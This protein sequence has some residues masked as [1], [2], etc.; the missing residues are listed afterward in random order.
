MPLREKDRYATPPPPLTANHVSQ[1]PPLPNLVRWGHPVFVVCVHS[2]ANTAF[3]WPSTALSL[4]VFTACHGHGT[5][6]HCPSLTFRCF[7][8]TLDYDFKNGNLVRHRLCLVLPLHSRLRHCYCLVCYHCLHGEGTA[9]AL[10]LHCLRG[11]GTAFAVCASTAHAA[12]NGAFPCSFHCLSSPVP[13]P[14]RKTAPCFAAKDSAFCLVCFHCRHSY[15]CMMAVTA[16]GCSGHVRA[17]KQPLR[18][19]RAAGRAQG[20]WGHCHG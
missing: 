6:F 9:F 18:A 4:R 15:C 2:G 20:D 8:Q 5:A 16:L 10:C 3:H 14:S 1:T 19:G 12:K 7:S 17:G 13:L 11:E